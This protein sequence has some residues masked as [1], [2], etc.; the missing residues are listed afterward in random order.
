MATK[1]APTERYEGHGEDSKWP[2]VKKGEFMAVGTAVPLQSK[3]I[4]PNVKE[5]ASSGGEQ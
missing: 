2:P 3:A 5:G 1:Q 4:S